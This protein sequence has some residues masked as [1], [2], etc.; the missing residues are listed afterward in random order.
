MQTVTINNYREKLKNLKNKLLTIKQ[1]I[2][3]S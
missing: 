3:N 1:K 2:I